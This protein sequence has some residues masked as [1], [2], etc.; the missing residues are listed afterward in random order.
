MVC[1]ERLETEGRLRVFGSEQEEASKAVGEKDKVQGPSLERMPWT[2]LYTKKNMIEASAY[3]SF[4]GFTERKFAE[5]KVAPEETNS[6][7]RHQEYS[8]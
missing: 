7:K 6:P 2:L 3:A 8:L 1:A 5:K 4:V